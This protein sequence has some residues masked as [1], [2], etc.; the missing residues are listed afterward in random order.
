MST[1]DE[2]KTGL[3]PRRTFM[4]DDDL[5]ALEGSDAETKVQERVDLLT[6]ARRLAMRQELRELAKMAEAM[7][8]DRPSLPPRQLGPA[9]AEGSGSRISLPPP[10]LPPFPAPP[11]ALP[12]ASLPPST[13]APVL[14]SP[15]SS[16]PSSRASLSTPPPM[17]A[18]SPAS[19]ASI[20]PPFISSVPLAAEGAVGRGTWAFLIGMVALAIPGGILLGQA[21]RSPPAPGAGASAMAPEALPSWVPAPLPSATPAPSATVASSLPTQDVLTLPIPAPSPARPR[22]PGHRVERAKP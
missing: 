2:R 15:P 10:S 17:M 11:R 19:S 14:S 3:V 9:F 7:P 8:M 21:L 6:V 16:P 18:A 5:D 20:R 12:P 13:P 4:D 22:R 1:Q